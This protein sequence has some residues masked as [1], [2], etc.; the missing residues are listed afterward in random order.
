LGKKYLR[1]F[2]ETDKNGSV[3]FTT[4]YPG[5]Y[6]GRALHIHIKI[7]TFEGPLRTFEW[8][9]QLYFNDTITDKVQTLSPYSNHGLRDT[10]N[11]EDGI[12]TGPSTDGLISSGTGTHLMLNLTK[13][14]LGY[15]GTFNVVVNS[16]QPRQ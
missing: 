12:Y 11:N 16:G 14:K 10:R 5:W 8:T 3:Q 13:E 7:R 1:G 4:I 6:Q 2:Q 15:L 9:S